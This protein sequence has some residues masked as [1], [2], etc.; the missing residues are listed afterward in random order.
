MKYAIVYLVKGKV[1]TYHKKLVNKFSSMFKI[2]NLNSYISPHLTL[3]APFM[4]KKI[5]DIETVLKKFVINHKPT[6]IK[7]H[8]IGY[9][10]KHVLYMKADFSNKANNIYKDLIRCLRKIS[11]MR[12]RKYDEIPGKFHATLGYAKNQGQFEE[13]W[14]YLMKQKFNFTLK[15]DNLTIIKKVNNKWV[16]HR[17]FKIK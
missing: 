9:F 3:K 12:W 10:D 4:T 1:G 11:W 6:I 16:V 14:E 7:M 17:I 2:K 13:M 5:K 8:K 15:F